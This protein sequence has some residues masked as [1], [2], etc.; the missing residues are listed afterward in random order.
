MTDMVTNLR[1]MAAIPPS[2]DTASLIC[3]ENWGK[4]GHR[5]PVAEVSL[6]R[7]RASISRGKQPEQPRKSALF[8]P[9]FAD[10]PTLVL[11][12]SKKAVRLLAKMLAVRFT[13]L[14][15]FMPKSSLS[16]RIQSVK[17]GNQRHSFVISLSPK[18]L[19]LSF[20][21]YSALWTLHFS[22]PTAPGTGC[23]GRAPAGQSRTDPA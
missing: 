23:P 6:I 9:F 20:T 18:S 8:A 21:L 12:C 2:P 3:G 11:F 5:P 22:L 16:K 17:Y 15:P 13:A 1:S 19:V 4:F 7:R 14:P 10:H